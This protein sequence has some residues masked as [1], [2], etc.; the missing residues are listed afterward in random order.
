LPRE[1]I[2]EESRKDKRYKDASNMQR[3]GSGEGMKKEDEEEAVPS[4]LALSMAAMRLAAIIHDYV[5]R[6]AAPD[7]IS[8]AKL[9]IRK[10]LGQGNRLL[11]LRQSAGQ[12]G[13]KV[14]KGCNLCVLTPKHCG[15]NISES[16]RTL[17]RHIL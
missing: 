6:I 13:A 7:E 1:D 3:N 10:T 9:S 8:L 12:M 5:L 16:K 11:W 4:T 17:V 2:D 14:S 15:A